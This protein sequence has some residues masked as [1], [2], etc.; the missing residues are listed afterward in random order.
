MTDIALDTCPVNHASDIPPQWIVLYGSS[1][2][3][4]SRRKWGSWAIEICTLLV[5]TGQWVIYR[6]GPDVALKHRSRVDA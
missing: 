3:I 2:E 1:D 4:S 6:D 5:G